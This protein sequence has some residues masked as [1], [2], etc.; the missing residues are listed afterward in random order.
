MAT[1][2]K[3][4]YIGML[5]YP[6]D[7]SHVSALDYICSNY[8]DYAYILHDKDTEEDGK[9][10]KAHYHLICYFKNAR[11]PSAVAKELQ[12]QPNYVQECGSQSGLLT[13]LIHYN[14]PEKYQY[15]LEEV[16]G[17][18]LSK[19]KDILNKDGLSECE[20]V[21]EL[22]RFIESCPIKMTV[23]KFAFY[24]AEEGYWDIFRRSASIFIRLIEEQNKK[25]N[26]ID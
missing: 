23:S 24:C 22:M 1:D 9:L 14:D 6:D 4:R 3:K 12:I 13:Y 25:T 5:L 7:D 18:L 16:H 15:P 8:T 19:L 26:L 20:K 11:F 2:K 17:P 10:K 21:L